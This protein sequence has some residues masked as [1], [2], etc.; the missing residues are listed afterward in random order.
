VD[1]RGQ[2][3]F[4]NVTIGVEIYIPFFNTKIEACS[5]ADLSLA[6]QALSTIEVAMVKPEVIHIR[7]TKNN[8]YIL[9][10]PTYFKK[11][12]PAVLGALDRLHPRLIAEGAVCGTSVLQGAH[13][14][15]P[16]C[17]STALSRWLRLF[18]QKY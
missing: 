18:R 4:G 15:D 8:F 17:S 9:V 2:A 11:G 13:P 14:N 16:R 10:T 3:C 6:T 5:S 7:Q 12:D 1:D